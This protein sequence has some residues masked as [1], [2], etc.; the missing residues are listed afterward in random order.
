VAERHRGAGTRAVHAGL[1]APEQGAPFLPGP[2]FA[3]SYHLAGDATDAPYGGYHRYGNPTWAAYELALGELEGGEAVLFAS[4]MAAVSAVLLPAGRPGAVVVARDGYP[5]ARQIAR[6]ELVP[7]GTEVR[8]VPTDAPA[9][10]DALPGAGLVWLE[11]PANPR[12]EVVDIEAVAAH[13]HAHGALV[14]VDNTLA[15]PLGQRPLDLGAD[16]SVTSASKSM[17]GHS[18]L[19]MG[20][21][22]SR[23]PEFVDALR[24]WRGLTGA[25]AGPQEAW[26]AHRS[27]ATLDLRLERTCANAQALAE[28]LAARP[29]VVEV[30]YPGL[31]HHEG[32][33]VAA[34]QMR[35]FGPVVSFT[36]ADAGTAQRFLAASELVFEATSFGGLHTTAERRGRWG[37]DEVAEGLIRLSAGCEDADDLLADVAAA[38]DRL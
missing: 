4:G 21:A 17:T 13:A 15:T 2:A 18:D 36:L 3:S 26:L 25:I 24:R 38:L 31:P 37:T 10:H 1:P 30:R 33:A 29:D 14:V 22:A 8:L 23:D 35:R 9:I 28:L 16:V 20:Y 5:G 7:R 34:R 19:L 32:H 6:E 12:L 11:T 27:L